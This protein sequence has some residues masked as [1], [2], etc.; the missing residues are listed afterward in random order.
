MDL[1]LFDLAFHRVTKIHWFSMGDT[2]DVLRY[3]FD[4]GTVQRYPDERVTLLKRP[5]DTDGPSLL[6]LAPAGNVNWFTGVNRRKNIDSECYCW[7]YRG[8]ID[9]DEE[10]PGDVPAKVVDGVDNIFA[11]NALW[12]TSGGSFFTVGIRSV[13]SKAWVWLSKTIQT[14]CSESADL[15][16]SVV[17]DVRSFC[18]AGI[19]AEKEVERWILLA[20]IAQQSFSTTDNDV[21]SLRECGVVARTREAEMLNVVLAA[22]DQKTK[23]TAGLCNA[24]DTI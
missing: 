20:S 19:E 1:V 6:M 12:K 4:T 24:R 5:N 10:L 21:T 11:Q 17:N 2:D 23:A 3:E 8:V 9:D 22:S 15:V 16:C 18:E 13:V 7:R 14:P